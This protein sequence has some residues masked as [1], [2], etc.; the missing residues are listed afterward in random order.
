MTPFITT[1]ILGTDNDDRIIGTRYQDQIA[2]LDG[3]DTIRSGAGADT[4]DG[5]GG[6]DRITDIQPWMDEGQPVDRGINELHGGLGDDRITADDRSFLPFQAS[7]DYR[8]HGDEGNDVVQ[9]ISGRGEVW[10]GA[11]NDKIFLAGYG[12][13]AIGGDGDD[14]VMAAGRARINDV[15]DWDQYSPGGLQILDGGT[16]N[17]RIFCYGYT[18]DTIIFTPNS[19][20][21]VV[22]NF[23]TDADYSVIDHLDLT[24]FDLNMTADQ[25][26][27]RYAHDR[28]D[29]VILRLDGETSLRILGLSAEDLGDSLIF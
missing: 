18:D 13:A 5:G 26:L 21:D 3:N 27:D 16:G 11:G 15:V 17:D 2:G 6:D 1:R 23:N 29:S 19:G 28:G 9:I 7:V 12:G 14:L 25:F 22:H 10:G 8:L 4:V 20:R 24:A